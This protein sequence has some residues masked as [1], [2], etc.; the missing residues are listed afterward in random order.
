MRL[1]GGDTRV[2]R[3]RGFQGDPLKRQSWV[4]HLR[5]F[6]KKRC[7]SFHLYPCKISGGWGREFSTEF[8]DRRA[9]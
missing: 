8:L 9:A 4:R 2:S 1:Q 6:P 5:H 7:L 3:G